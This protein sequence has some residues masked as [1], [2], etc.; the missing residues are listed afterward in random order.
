MNTSTLIL[1]LSAGTLL[2]ASQLASANDQ[3]DAM[4]KSAE[5]STPG[6]PISPKVIQGTP[7]SEDY[8]FPVA[9]V[10]PDR[11]H[12]CGG[13]LIDATTVITAAHCVEFATAADLRVLHGTQTI[14][15]GGQL[16]ELAQNPII[17][18]R[19]S[20]TNIDYDVAVLKLGQSL[21]GPYAA[22]MGPNSNPQLTEP[23][24]DGL[25]I[26]WGVSDPNDVFQGSN[27]L[28]EGSQTIGDQAECR[29]RIR[30][31]S[32][33]WRMTDRMMCGIHGEVTGGPCYGDSGGPMIRRETEDG[34]WVQVGVVSWGF[35]GCVSPERMA[36]YTR[37]SKFSDWLA[38]VRRPDA[39]LVA[40]AEKYR[41]LNLDR[42]GF[43]RTAADARPFEKEALA[44]IEPIVRY[45]LGDLPP[46]EEIG[47][48]A[49]YILED[50]AGGGV[51]K[52]AIL[53]KVP[54]SP[55]FS[56]AFT[57]M[58]EDA[59]YYYYSG[60][61]PYAD[62]LQIVRS[63][64]LHDWHPVATL[65]NGLPHLFAFDNSGFQYQPFTSRIREETRL[66][67][68]KRIPASG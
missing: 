1:A 29:Q 42:I 17:H 8:G 9:L 32:P 59:D 31:W 48:S 6:G 39:D 27:D 35:P 53:F 44:A 68:Q 3:I 25:V 2:A 40:V 5:Q 46:L 34:P 7:A 30:D 21:E 22:V 16:V 10:T 60:Y 45:E 14:D 49:Q 51:K 4:N 15:S 43:N 56:V 18:P 37:L 26:G 50:G 28:L 64:T 20:L 67:I 55:D 58:T 63:Q 66:G 57:A 65:I 54:V 12:F 47:I 13:T 24:S 33:Y 52:L 23:G 61:L 41:S 19:Y 62:N 38:D 36:I 11:Q